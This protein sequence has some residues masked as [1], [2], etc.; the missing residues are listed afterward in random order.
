VN[1]AFIQ[2]CV[3]SQEY[4]KAL[5]GSFRLGEQGLIDKVYNSIPHENVEFV[6]K[7][8][9]SKYFAKFLTAL[10]RQFDINPRLEFHLEWA[11]SFL[12][13]NAPYLRNNSQ[14]YAP[15][16]RALHK[17]MSNVTKEIGTL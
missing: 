6:V 7:D 2:K 12:K 3:K 9:G 10:N 17:H 16:L 14:E 5:I 13:L 8:V 4:T 11:V 1:P 15:I